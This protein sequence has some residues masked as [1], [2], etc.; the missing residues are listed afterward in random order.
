MIR[1]DSLQ[2]RLPA[3]YQHRARN[4]AGLVSHS[5]ASST[6]SGSFRLDYLST[7][8]VRINQNSTDGEIAHSIVSGIVASIEARK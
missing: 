7:P 3:G 4:I 5:L 6:M 2:I 1:V 8:A